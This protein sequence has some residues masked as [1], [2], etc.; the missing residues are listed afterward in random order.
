MQEIKTTED[1]MVTLS[2]QQHV[3]LPAL[4]EV[5]VAFL[6]VIRYLKELPKGFRLAIRWLKD[7]PIAFRFAIR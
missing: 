5:S 2:M 6:S 3:R 4:K 7:L 1:Q